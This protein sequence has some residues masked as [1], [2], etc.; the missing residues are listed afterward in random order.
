MFDHERKVYGFVLEYIR[1]AAADIDESAMT[2]QPTPAMN[3]PLWIL[4]HLAV[5]TDYAL[6][7]LG[8]KPQCPKEWHKAFGMGSRPVSEWNPRPS[9][10]EL[11]RAIEAGHE[12]VAAASRDATPEVLERPHPVEPLK[13]TPIRTV[14]DLVSHLM[15]T[16]PMFHLG[17]LSYWR[18]QQGFAPMF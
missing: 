1:K 13:N 9:K 6:M 7:N 3:P 18:R 10:A 5:A 4:G 16:H 12:K 2:H 14:G 11:L 17:Q 15:T 8:Q